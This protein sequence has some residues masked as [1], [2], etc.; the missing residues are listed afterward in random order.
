M[1]ATS[2]VATPIQGYRGRGI[3]SGILPIRNYLEAATQTFLQGTPVQINAAGF[4]QA[5]AAITSVATAVVAGISL[6]AGAN[7]GTAGVAQTQ[8]LTN[9]VPNQPNAVITPIGAPPNDGTSQF[10]LVS[11]DETFMGKMG[12]SN[13]AAN[14]VLAQAQVGTLMGLTKD[15][16]TG[17]W[18][19]DNYITTTAAGACV[20]IDA[21]VD[22]VGTLNGR[23]E[24]HFTNAAQQ[25]AS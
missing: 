2:G 24:F 8:N 10:I 13:T 3:P 19:V 1:A 7:L 5:A 20:V 17:F 22:P 9:K 4:L 16:G 23:V 15:A 21:L 11:S 6:V 14:A 18:Y 25:L 12:N